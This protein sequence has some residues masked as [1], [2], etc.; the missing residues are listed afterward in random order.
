MNLLDRTAE[1]RLPELVLAAAALIDRAGLDTDDARVASHPDARVVRYYQS[2][3]LVERPLRYEGRA[4]LYGW[5]HLV[6]VVAV[7]LLQSQG[8]GLSRIQES[9]A[10]LPFSR[11][12]AAVLQ[13][14][15]QAPQAPDQVL[16]SGDVLPAGEVLRL[17]APEPRALIAVEL[18]PGVRLS[19]DPA[20]VPD[21]T[22]LIR[23]L[24]AALAE[25]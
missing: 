5:R 16:R 3:G 25:R 14:V 17:T 10:G 12:E 1:R 7:K 11:L 13:A 8:Y 2:L 20:L 23:R 15:A 24:S 4:A 22:A 18:Q 9:F 21:P 6:Q 19:V